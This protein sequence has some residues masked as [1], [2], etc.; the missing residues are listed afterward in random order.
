MHHRALKHMQDKE[1]SDIVGTAGKMRMKSMDELI[2]HV[3]DLDGC[4]LVVQGCACCGEIH[5]RSDGAVRLQ[6]I[7][8]WLRK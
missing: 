1:R 2:M 5:M 6:A 7:L 4:M 8:K 3:S